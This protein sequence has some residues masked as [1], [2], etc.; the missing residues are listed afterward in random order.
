MW[1]RN[2][3]YEKL[4]IPYG[5]AKVNAMILA[6]P[7]ISGITTPHMHSFRFLI[8][9]ENPTDE[10]MKYYSCEY[11]VDKNTP[12]AFIWHTMP[13]SCVN[14]KNSL[15]FA[16][17]LSENNIPYELHIFPMGEHGLSRAN[18]ESAPY[19]EYDIPYVS[20]WAEWSVTWLKELF[21][22]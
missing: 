19:I 12:P 17:V 8:G 22:R 9:K 11:N 18:S 2:D 15:V 16:T 4:G 10:E 3:L 13:D 21:Q 20:R 5:T 1:H 7:L 14:V 6:Y